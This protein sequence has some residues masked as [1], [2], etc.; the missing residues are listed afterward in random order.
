MAPRNIAM[1][2]MS[3][4]HALQICLLVYLAVSATLA[5]EVLANSSVQPIVL[6]VHGRGQSEVTADEVRNRF[7]AAFLAEERKLYGQEV[8]PKEALRFAWYADVIDPNA[9]HFPDS[10]NC[11]FNT[12]PQL[13]AAIL[14][15]LRSSLIRVAQ[16]AKLDDVGLQV[17]AGDTYKYLTRPEIR[18]EADQ[19]VLTELSAAATAGHKIVLVAHSMGGIVSFSAL[20]KISLIQ[21]QNP[22]HAASFVTIGT[23]IGVTEVLQ[24]LLGQFT[25]PPVPLPLSIAA[26]ANFRNAGDRLSF[27]TEGQFKATQIA[28]EPIDLPVRGTGPAHS[29]ETYLSI[30]DVTRRIV[31]EWCAVADAPPSSCRGSAISSEMLLPDHEYIADI[32]G[33]FFKLPTPKILETSQMEATGVIGYGSNTLPSTIGVNVSELA[34]LQRL[35]PRYKDDTFFFILAHETAHVVQKLRRQPGHAPS[36]LVDECEADIWGATA[37]VAALPFDGNGAGLKSKLDAVISIVGETGAVFDDVESDLREQFDRHPRSEQRAL[38]AAKGA[39]SGLQMIRLQQIANL[40]EPAASAA[41]GDVKMLDPDM[42]ALRNDLWTWS[43]KNAEG[44]ATAT[45]NAKARILT[46]EDYAHLAIAAEAGSA[47]LAAAGAAIPDAP[48]LKCKIETKTA[49]TVAIC[50]AAMLDSMKL[51][52]IFFDSLRGILKPTLLSRGWIARSEGQSDGGVKETF[53]KG[54]ASAVVEVDYR[55]SQVRFS[56]ASSRL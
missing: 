22:V 5:P 43:R 1:R 18:C 16:A 47:S 48:P 36:A 4:T 38:C 28:R 3:K 23:Q 54:D 49:S 6:F 44:I 9:E 2:V 32:I 31:D 35:D 10:E 14:S 11:R 26:W 34:V 41:L 55:D 27:A 13:S 7:F 17:L 33:I 19:R 24:G 45:L 21:A 8:V 40:R 46:Q 37:L 51:Q 20:Q 15:G 53:S 25:K 42:Y 30:P 39:S 50:T 56:I 52:Y 12:A 29:A